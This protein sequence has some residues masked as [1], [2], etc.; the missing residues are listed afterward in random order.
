MQGA[1]SLG[2]GLERALSLQMG[3]HP[4]EA[5]NPFVCLFVRPSIRPSVFLSIRARCNDGAFASSV[6]PYFP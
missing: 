3:Y 2:L 6:L 4:Q 5:N 1:F